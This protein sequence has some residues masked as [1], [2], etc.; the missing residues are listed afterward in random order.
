MT[1]RVIGG[2]YASIIAIVAVNT[3]INTIIYHRT[4]SNDKRFCKEKFRNT[5]V[6]ICVLFNDFNVFNC[7][8]HTCV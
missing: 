7:I 5:A 3:I 2:E 4:M 1:W 6:D 8:M